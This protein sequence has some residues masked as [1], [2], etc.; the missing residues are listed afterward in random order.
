M[1]DRQDEYVLLV[2]FER[3]HVGEPFDGR[4]ASQRACCPCARPYR[5]GFWGAVN[6]TEGRRNLSEELVAQSWT[7]LVVPKGGATQLVV[8][9]RIVTLYDPPTG[10]ASTS[11]NTPLPRYMKY[12]AK[13]AKRFAGSPEISTTATDSVRG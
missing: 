3:D 8:A 12:S 10:A 2:L 1:G 11:S 13:G 9:Y 7:S 6:S 5:V 4:L